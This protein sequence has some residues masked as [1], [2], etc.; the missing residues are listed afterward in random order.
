MRIKPVR[1][2]S[3]FYK[4]LDNDEFKINYN[5]SKKYFYCRIPKS[6]VIYEIG[7][8]QYNKKRKGL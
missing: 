6:V 8:K 2:D 1:Y 4:K 7:D 3:S 5:K